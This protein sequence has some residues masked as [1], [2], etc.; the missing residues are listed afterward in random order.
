MRT[1]KRRCPTCHGT[2][3]LLG[4]TKAAGS[5]LTAQSGTCPDCD[6]LGWLGD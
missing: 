5:G 6:G 3:Q 1:G 4:M 2:G